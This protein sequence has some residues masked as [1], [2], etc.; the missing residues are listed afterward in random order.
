MP[1]IESDK[2]LLLGMLRT[3]RGTFKFLC[4]SC[5]LEAFTAG[6]IESFLGAY[7]PDHLPASADTC[8]R[9]YE[10]AHPGPTVFLRSELDGLPRRRW[11]PPPDGNFANTFHRCGH[12]G[13]MAIIAGLAPLPQQTRPNEV[14]LF[15]FFSQRRKPVKAL[16]ASSTI[17]SR[18]YPS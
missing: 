11:A 1:V 15:C 13:H 2:V 4:G 10:S 18:L 7:A 9:V 12:D 3:L 14:V 16:S 17:R 8:R 6:V 5:G